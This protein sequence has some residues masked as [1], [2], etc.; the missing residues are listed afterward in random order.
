M[1]GSLPVENAGNGPLC[2]FVEPYGEDLWLEPGE[3]VMVS[4]VSDGVNVQFAVTV[5]DELMSA[6]LFEDGDP[7][8]VVLESQVSIR[9]AP[10]WSVDTS[11]TTAESPDRSC[12]GES[13]PITSLTPARDTNMGE[14]PWSMPTVSGQPVE[15]PNG[16]TGIDSTPSST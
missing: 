2:H 14:Q 7:S 10:R 11:V 5:A 1:H 3:A 6:W 9:L 4:P 15:A 16:R 12:V 13:S 8:R